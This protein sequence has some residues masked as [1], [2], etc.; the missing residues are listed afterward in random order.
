MN[1]IFVYG[2]LKDGFPN[3]YLLKNKDYGKCTFCYNARTVNKYPLV[4][5]TEYDIPFMLDLEETGHCIDGEVYDVDNI[6]LKKLDEIESHPRF[7]RRTPIKVMPLQTDDDSIVECETYLLVDFN[8]DLL[9]MK[10]IKIYQNSLK[11]V[12]SDKRP[13]DEIIKYIKK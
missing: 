7:Y 8:P 12:P 1:K 4:V 13:Q 10:F 6:M 9:K 11:Y 3:N 2:T 5:A